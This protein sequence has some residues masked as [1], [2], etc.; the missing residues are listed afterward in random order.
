MDVGRLIGHKDRLPGVIMGHHGLRARHETTQQRDLALG[1][2]APAP[3][4]HPVTSDRDDWP[5]LVRPQH[6]PQGRGGVHALTLS[7][8]LAQRCTLIPLAH[9]RLE[10]MLTDPQ[11]A[12]TVDTQQGRKQ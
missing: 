7:P 11:R 6:R 2:G 3:G 1:H 8:T 5:C 9:Q 4:G 12:E 10:R